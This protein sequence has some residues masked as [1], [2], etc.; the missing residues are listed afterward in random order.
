MIK[1]NEILKFAKKHNLMANIIEKDYI[2]G[3]VLAGI[4]KHPDLSKSWLFKGGTCIKK[5]FFHDYRFS[6]DL[7]FTLKVP[8]TIDE[9]DLI[10]C[11]YNVAD[12]IYDESGI[13][14]VKNEIG[15]EKYKTPRDHVAIQGR[16]G[17]QGPLQRQ[18]NYARIKI[19]L[20]CEEKIVLKSEERNVFHPYSDCPPHGMTVNAYCLEEIFAEKIRALIDRTRPRDI[21]DV[22]HFYEKQ[23]EKLDV[24]LVKDVFRKKCEFKKILVPR[25]DVI[26]SESN[27]EE[28]KSAWYHML[29][30]QLSELPDFELCWKKLPKIL[31]VYLN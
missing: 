20:T 13:V 19:D 1:R 28:I 21:Y 12:W 3:W 2:L 11:F 6:E 17:Y 31:E 23:A 22:I 16:I 10:K 7:D 4:S 26:V 9:Q 24:S 25:I 5:C 15:F 29:G 27:R 14:L 8:Q 30:H 18:G